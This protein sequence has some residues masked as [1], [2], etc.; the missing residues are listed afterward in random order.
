MG[1]ADITQ[2]AKMGLNRK[3]QTEIDKA[4]KKVDE[5]VLEFDTI[6]E[7][8]YSATQPNQK[9]KYEGDLKKEIKKLQRHRDGIKTWIASNDI[10]DKKQL[11][12]ARKLIESKM[13]QFKICEKETKTK[14]FS[15]EGLARAQLMDPEEQARN[16]KREWLQGRI[17]DLNEQLEG[18]E[19][20]IEKLNTGKKKK[21]AEVDRFHILENA[22]AQHR[23]HIGRL[24]QIMRLMDNGDLEPD[25]I[26]EIKDDLDYYIE[27]AVDPESI[28]MRGSGAY[29]FYEP[30]DLDSIGGAKLLIAGAKKDEDGSDVESAPAVEEQPP[31]EE[32]RMPSQDTMEDDDDDKSGRLSRRGSRAAMGSGA[33]PIVI[34]RPV[35]QSRKEREAAA[36]AAKALADKAVTDTP[37]LP[38]TPASISTIPP[39]TFDSN[40]SSTGAPPTPSSSSAKVPTPTAASQA[41]AAGSTATPAV[42]TP[43]LQQPVTSSPKTMSPAV[44]LLPTQHNRPAETPTAPDTSAAGKTSPPAALLLPAQVS[45]S[46]PPALGLPTPLQT[47][48]AQTP[49]AL[50]QQRTSAPA[51]MSPPPPL[52]DIHLMTTGPSGPGSNTGMPGQG[53]AGPGSLSF[54]QSNSPFTSGGGPG[55]A[56]SP[57]GIKM[58]PLMGQLSAGAVG[59]PPR[60]GSETPLSARSA[61]GGGGMFP[62][63]GVGIEGAGGVP[64]QSPSTSEAGMPVSLTGSNSRDRSTSVELGLSMPLPGQALAAIGTNPAPPVA[65]PLLARSGLG[66]TAPR[67]EGQGV[68]GAGGGPP[69]VFGGDTDAEM[70]K[71]LNQSMQFVPGKHDSER[72]TAYVPRNPYRTPP[73]FP[74]QPSGAFEN[75]LI[76][77]K[78]STDTLFFI[79]YYQQGT[80]QQYLAAR[81]LK[82]QSWRYHKKYMTWFQRHEE[83]KVTTD[84]YEQGTYVYFDYETGWC[85]RIKSDFTFEYSF[86]EDEILS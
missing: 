28:E 38:P 3:L 42:Q 56:L 24:E 58:S 68:I 30:L 21:G 10:K 78:L 67:G 19:A 61:T 82:R 26:E 45:L 72:H 43:Q 9:E 69:G 49:Q 79:F 27:S 62:P 48:G 71:L 32:V 60:A 47:Q 81:E 29:D 36:A 75:P 76:F 57:A 70:A 17:D 11:I 59:A 52:D 25:Q 64:P 7:K 33:M 86:L 22:L 77:E 20:D 5:G 44:P 85:Q 40:A 50:V 80:Y 16:E 1:S 73:A 31:E 39:L 54:L 51:T 66:L 53:G 55:S 12:D 4:L 37:K 8:V 84:D 65:P 15:K 41:A 18:F 63:P 14:A 83:P 74:Q 6:W 13:E 2:M 46:V 34:G 23:Y 35:V